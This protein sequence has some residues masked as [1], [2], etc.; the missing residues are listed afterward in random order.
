[1]QQP[2]ANNASQ[3]EWV[4]LGIVV[5]DLEKAMHDYSSLLSIGP[6]RTFGVEQ[7]GVLVA[8]AAFG[9]I[10]LELIQPVRR[11]NPLWE[12]LG[13]EAVR[14]HH[15]GFDVADTNAEVAR[16]QALGIRAADTLSAA[17]VRATFLDT[18]Q[19][20]GLDFELIEGWKAVQP[21][22]QKSKS[23]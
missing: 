17:H 6:F 13:D 23:E 16:F 5:R 21:G 2:K 20:A 15:F 14:L 19:V 1:M 8:V 22:A 9:P 18:K 12:F 3:A 10:Q 7:F 4:Q 11:E